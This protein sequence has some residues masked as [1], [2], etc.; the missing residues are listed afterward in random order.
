M[1]LLPTTSTQ[2]KIYDAVRLS[3]DAS[4]A[5]RAFA[6]PNANL[7]FGRFSTRAAAGYSA[8]VEFDFRPAPSLEAA[9]FVRFSAS[10]IKPTVPLRPAVPVRQRV[11]PPG[12]IGVG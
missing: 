12:A 9:A 8:R 11:A 5:K 4:G 2:K 3:A 7:A 6:D 1:S 10:S